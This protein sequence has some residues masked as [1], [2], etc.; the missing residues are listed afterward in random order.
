MGR[1]RDAIGFTGD[2]IAIA[3]RMA[4]WAADPPKL[5]GHLV[6]DQ[7]MANFLSMDPEKGRAMRSHIPI[8]GTGF[9]R[10]G[11]LITSG[12]AS[13]SSTRAFEGAPIDLPKI[14]W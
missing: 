7:E 1:K 12:R 2:G 10:R 9:A 4:P 3:K 6:P 5:P 11:A 14:C 13:H 8:R